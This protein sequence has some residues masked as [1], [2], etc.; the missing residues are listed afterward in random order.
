MATTILAYG[1][2]R[3]TKTSQFRF[4]AEKVW[5][6]SGKKSR[7]ITSDTGSL[8]TPIQ[9]L[10]DADIVRPLLLPVDPTFNPLPAMRK[11]RRGAWPKDNV[12]KK[13]M[14]VGDWLEWGAQPDAKEIGSYGIEGLTS[15]GD[16]AMRDLREKNVKIGTDPV[17]GLRTEDGETFAANTQNHYSAVHAEITTLLNSLAALPVEYVYITALEGIGE[18]DDGPVKKA[19]LGP[20]VPGKAITEVIPSMVN[21]CIH[22]QWAANG[23]GR[24]LRAYIAGHASEVP[25]KE[26]PAG[27]RLPS[28]PPVLAA[29]QKKWPNGY[30]ILT[31]DKG[32]G[33]LLSFQDEMAELAKQ[34]TANLKPKV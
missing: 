22:M 28:V 30:F 18:D 25:S 14:Q 12:M 9:D 11:L 16:G 5:K 6:D 8:W 10:V 17:P 24:E 2:T 21:D 7:F 31:P 32:I 3:T 15:Y 26:W 29:V 27:L 13:G 23:N 4:I 20:K 34:Y 19:I 33:E 1:K